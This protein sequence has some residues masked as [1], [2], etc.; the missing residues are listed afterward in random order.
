MSVRHPAVAGVFYP[1]DPEVLRKTVQNLLDHAEQHHI[2]PK[3]LVVPHA[4]LIYSGAIAASAYAS[5]INHHHKITKI[6]LLGPAHTLYFKGIAYDP[7]DYFATPL[8]EIKQDQ[9]LLQR[10]KEF[11]YVHALPQAHTKEHCLEVQ[12]PFCQMIFPQFTILPLVVGETSEEEVAQLLNKV[13]GEDETLIIISSDLSHYLPYDQ[14]QTTDNKTCIAI[15]TLNAESI[16]HKGACGYYPLRGFLHHARK[17]HLYGHLLDLRN[18]GDTVGN[19]SKVVGYA[20]YYF[21]QNLHFADHCGDELKYLAKQA[22]RL[23]AEDNINL[24]IDY[25]DFNELLQ[26]RLPTFVTLKKNGMLRG[27]MGTLTSQEHLADNVIHNSIKAGFADPRFPHLTR[28]ELED[29]SLSISILSPLEPLHFK[30]EDDLKAQ[31]H[32][33]TDGLVLISDGHQATF[34]PS[35]WDQLHTREEFLA[36][37]KLKMGVTTNYWSTDIQALRYTT[38]IIE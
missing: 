36:H 10:I 28:T 19:K 37:L 35:V 16:P 38:E 31:L 14:A 25:E 4:G 7:V 3:A 5:L 1:A 29:I 9:D 2:P 22:L 26:I 20:S 27:C 17:N 6:V 32:P 23:R 11:S 33:G 30:D 8:G 21:Y 15:D 34:L 12:L 24:R 18:S 13:W